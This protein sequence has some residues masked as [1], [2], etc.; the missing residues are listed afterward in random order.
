MAL[1][2]KMAPPVRGHQVSNR[3]LQIRSF[4]Q[5]SG[6]R[7]GVLYNHIAHDHLVVHVLGKFIS[8]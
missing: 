5:I 6:E 3:Y 2:P 7:F 1:G 4:K 8:G